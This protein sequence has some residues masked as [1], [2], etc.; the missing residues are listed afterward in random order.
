MN[1]ETSNQAITSNEV[2]EEIKTHLREANRILF[3]TGAGMSAD[4]GLPTYRGIGGL[5]NER[6]TD[7]EM[8]I[9]VALSGQMMA[10]QPEVTWKYLLEIERAC[11]GAGF[12]KGH[13]IIAEIGKHYPD[14]W[15][16]TQNIDG[17][18]RKA[19]SENLI[20]IHGRVSELYCTC[21]DANWTVAD[22]SHLEKLPFCERC[23]KNGLESVVR[24]NV[25]LFGEMLP[26]DAI[27]QLEE[28]LNAGFDLIFSIGTTSVF[29]YI[30]QPVIEGFRLGVPTVEINPGDTEV[31]QYCRYKL[32]MGAKEAL[33]RIWE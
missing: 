31:T 17:F 15:V 24:P 11:R 4:S 32:A 27:G 14:T 3:I 10:H 33:E 26:S 18:H 28:Q 13:E 21:C 5:Y 29:P 9:E 6:L 23:A 2:I 25:V 16:L 8:P 1:V 22:Y 30:S 19:G 20:E 12:N 7:D